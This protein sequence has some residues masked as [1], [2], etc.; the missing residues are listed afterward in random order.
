M[1]P[2]VTATVCILIV[3]SCLGTLFNGFVLAVFSRFRN[4]HSSTTYILILSSV[5]ICTC[6]VT[7]PLCIVMEILEFET[8]SN[9]LCRSYHLLVTTTVPLSAILMVVIAIDRYVHICYNNSLFVST[10]VIIVTVCVIVL[11]ALVLGCLCAFGYGVEKIHPTFPKVDGNFSVTNQFFNACNNFPFSSEYESFDTGI[12]KFNLSISIED[13]KEVSSYVLSSME[14]FL[15]DFDVA[16][17]QQSYDYFSA[18]FIDAYGKIYSSVY[19]FCCLFTIC[20]YGK[21]YYFVASHRRQSVNRYHPNVLLRS[22]LSSVSKGPS[23]ED[24]EMKSYQGSAGSENVIRMTFVSKREKMRRQ[25]IRTAIMLASVAFVFTASFLPAW[26]MKY[27]FIPFNDFVFH[28]YFI[29][30]IINPFIYSFCNS[31]FKVA[32]KKV[33]FTKRRGAFNL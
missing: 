32:L 14:D 16:I 1:E 30:C 10:C 27:R 22:Q 18:D 24:I 3:F 4:N 19:A 11:F 5:D 28:L 17:C 21:I 26:L 29:Y 12:Q 2:T 20:I 8:D 33:I 25:N 7:I 9:I 6:A 15:N 13:A 31:K 23:R